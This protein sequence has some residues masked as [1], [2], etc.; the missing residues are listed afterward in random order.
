MTRPTYSIVNAFRSPIL[1]I[2][3]PILSADHEKGRENHENLAPGPGQKLQCVEQPVALFQH[4]RMCLFD[5]G[6]EP[7]EADPHERGE[8]ATDAARQQENPDVVEI[9][10]CKQ[11][12][13]HGIHDQGRYGTDRNQLAQRL[14]RI[15]F[16]IPL[17]RQR[18]FPDR[19]R[20]KTGQRDAYAEERQGKNSKRLFPENQQHE[21]GRKREKAGYFAE[22]L[23][24]A[25]LD[26][27]EPGSFD[28]EIIEQGG[29]AAES[30]WHRHRHE[31][32]KRVRV[33]PGPSVH[34][35]F[36]TSSIKGWCLS[37]NLSSARRAFAKC[38]SSIG[39]Q[40]SQ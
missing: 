35:A 31:D 14:R 16:V 11:Y 6:I 21:Y 36:N 23:Q 38:V 28:D 20:K 10:E 3:L 22:A 39:Q 5:L 18:L 29:P 24:D 25:Y 15:H 19:A 32:Q 27:R 37:I 9:K 33:L 13:E 1:P 4:Q 17:Q 40:W 2:R 8:A 26:T 30:D 7:R 34:Q 12:P